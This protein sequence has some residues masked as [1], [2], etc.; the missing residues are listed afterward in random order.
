MSPRQLFIISLIRSFLIVTSVFSLFDYI[1]NPKSI[2]NIE[3]N[4]F[5][6]LLFTKISLFL[7]VMA[8]ISGI[9]NRLTGN[10]HFIKDFFLPIS[11]SFEFI[12]TLVYWILYLINKKLIVDSNT[13]IPGNETTLLSR[14]SSHIFPMILVCLEYI[15]FSPN[16][17][18]YHI[19]FFGIFGILYYIL[20]TVYAL[21]FGKY[22][23]PFLDNLN[24]IQRVLF[25]LIISVLGLI[26]YYVQF[27]IF[28]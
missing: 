7:T 11:F 8:S 20:V 1:D 18:E 22:I 17:N 4:N 10:Y 25:F 16:K 6:Y 9:I 26:V 5:K 3:Y 23:Y 19:I 14:L 21:W 2:S 27:K 15:D 28:D 24:T 13:L 12:V